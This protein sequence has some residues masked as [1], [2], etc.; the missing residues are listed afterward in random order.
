MSAHLAQALEAE[1]Q[2]L[3]QCQRENQELNAHNQVSLTG[4][5]ALQ[6]PPNVRLHQGV[7]RSHRRC[8]LLASSSVSRHCVV[9]AQGSIPKAG[10]V[11]K[12]PPSQDHTVLT[13]DFVRLFS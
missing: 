4:G 12:T 2:A 7:G 8:R 1:R 5:P 6:A 9:G 10:T 13:W 11:F 3:R